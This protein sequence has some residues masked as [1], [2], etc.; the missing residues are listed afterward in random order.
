MI[1]FDIYNYIHLYT[2]LFL[3]QFS[4]DEKEMLS[5]MDYSIL[6]MIPGVMYIDK[7]K[8]KGY[9]GTTKYRAS[10]PVK[11]TNRIFY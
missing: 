2:N 1:F 3:D 9:I 6:D 7:I 8:D 10:Q 5:I 4:D 11:A